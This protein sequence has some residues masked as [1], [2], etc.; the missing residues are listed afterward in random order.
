MERIIVTGGSGFIGSHLVDKLLELNYEVIS[1][2]NLITGSKQNLTQHKDNPNFKNIIHDVQDPLELEDIDYIFHLASPAS[3]IDYQN[4]PIETL[5]TGSIGT[6][7]ILEIAKNNNA[8]FLLASTSETYGDPLEHPQKETYFGNVNPIGPRSCY[9]EAKRFAEAITMAYHRE[10]NLNVVLARIFNTYGPRMRANDGRVMPNFI[11]QAL[12]N[13]DLTVYGSGSQTRSFCYVDDLVDGLMKLMFS[14]VSA[15]VVNLGNPDE[16]TILETAEKIKEI[17]GSKSN[18][19][20]KEI[21][22]DDPTRRKPDITKAKALLGWE[23][24]I[25]LNIGLK[26]TIEYFENLK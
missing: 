2:D 17:I 20:F 24:K 4:I 26:K 9:D 5:L 15:E 3:P 18:I 10:Y 25:E 12:E 21:P 8:R 13:E 1:I 11:N 19:I 16:Y 14:D 22:E 6:K 23:P 7:N